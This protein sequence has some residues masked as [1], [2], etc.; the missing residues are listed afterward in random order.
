MDDLAW[1][2][3]ALALAEGGCSVVWCGEGGARFYA[4]G[5]GETRRDVF[6]GEERVAEYLAKDSRLGLDGGANA[7]SFIRVNALVGLLSKDLLDLLLHFGHP[8]HSAHKDHLIN[9]LGADTGVLQRR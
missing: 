5:I 8:G 1:M 6:S 2:R 4:C 3:R 7:H 9:V